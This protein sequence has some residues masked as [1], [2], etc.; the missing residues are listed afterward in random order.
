MSTS[1][2][3]RTVRPSELRAERVHVDRFGYD[4]TGSYW[5]SSASP[6]LYRVTD[7]QGYL[8][9]HVRAPDAPT[10]KRRAVEQAGGTMIT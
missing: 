3:G 2:R 6:P 10:A 5:G 1:M 8:D 4:R 7:E 9:E